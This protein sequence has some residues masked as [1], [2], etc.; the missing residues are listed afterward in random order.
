MIFKQT[1]L[2]AGYLQ[3]HDSFPVEIEKRFKTLT[4]THKR[5][6]NKNKEERQERKA[7]LSSRGKGLQNYT[8]FSIKGRLIF[9][10][11]HI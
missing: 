2:H 8:D 10:I 4:K 11:K 3:K 5:K 6:T 1:V 9:T 7:V